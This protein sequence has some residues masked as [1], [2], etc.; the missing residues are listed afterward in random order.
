[1]FSVFVSDETEYFIFLEIFF[2]MDNL[3]W[4]DFELEFEEP[5][6]VS[7]I[8]LIKAH[9]ITIEE[10]EEMAVE[11]NIPSNVQDSDIEILEDIGNEDKIEIIEISESVS[12]DS[13]SQNN[14]QENFKIEILEHDKKVQ[15]NILGISKVEEAVEKVNDIATHQKDDTDKVFLRN[16]NFNGNYSLF[17]QLSDYFQ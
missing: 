7:N 4:M 9:S 14:V 11:S 12:D 6:E 5:S 1:M 8:T 10:F 15:E 3:H 16:N 17:C 13:I 2:K